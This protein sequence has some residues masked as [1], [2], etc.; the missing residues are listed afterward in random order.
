MARRYNYLL[1]NG[2]KLTGPAERRRGGGDKTP[3]YEFSHAQQ[4]IS[5]RIGKAA[6]RIKQLPAEACPGGEAILTLTM[7]PR[8]ISKTDFPESL[9]N[10]LGLRSVGSRERTV[11][12][13]KW[14]ID[15]HPQEAYTEEL[16]VAG[17][18]SRILQLKKYVDEFTPTSTGHEDLLHIEDIS[19][20]EPT[21]KLKL[22]N[23]KDSPEG[24]LEVVLHN[25]SHVDVLSAFNEYASPLGARVDFARR[26]DVGGLTFVPVA[27]NAKAAARLADFSFLRVARTMP[28]LRPLYPSIVR[29]TAKE[30]ATLP[31][32]TAITDG[33][34]ALIFDGGIPTGER[35]KLQPWVKVI[36]PPS[37]GP[38]VP[39]LEAHGLA[40]TS[41]FLFG[42]ISD[43]NGLR[44]PI[45][46]V[47]HVRVLDSDVIGSSDPYYYDVLDRI[48]AFFDAE[49]HR[50]VFIN[51]SVGPNLPI[52]DDEITLW[53]ARLDSRLAS[54]EW[55]TTVAAGNDGDKAALFGLNRIQPPADGVNLIGVGACNRTSS[56][57]T[58]ADYSC[59]G[60]GRRPGFVKPDGLAFG[61][62]EDEP[63]PVLSSGSVVQGVQGTSVAAPWA[64]RSG[65]TIKA[66]LGQSLGPLAI[67]ALMVHRA[68]P[69]EGLPL[70]EIGWGRFESD[71]EKLITCEDNEALVIYQGDLPE[72]QYLHAPIPLP[73][74]HLK[75][76]VELEATLVI[77]TD[78]DPSHASA[79]TRS[80]LET[81]FRP[82]ADRFTKYKD[83]KVS[84]YPTT[85]AFFSER[86]LYGGSE[87]K[88][89]EG[90]KWEPCV[91]G[92]VRMRATSLKSPA[93]DIYNH[94]R[95]NGTASQSTDKT[96]Y[97]LVVT[98]RAVRVRDL[99]SQVVRAYANILIPLRPQIRIEVSH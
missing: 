88:Q 71:P 66:Q 97:A 35:T 53:T 14:G 36:E 5:E 81:A 94:R 24:W 56:A 4:R 78:V 89:R 51:I 12:P 83:G 74:I 22:V 54:G 38:S 49:G 76:Y 59:P 20:P 42:P 45:C 57:W 62:S 68:L 98:V 95:A 69:A 63:F 67:R 16:F 30:F 7:H 96:K 90:G 19:Y 79:Y 31:E 17:P 61:G 46:P 43:V 80:G 26:R 1:G 77:A 99:Y 52:Y 41:A 3:P 11:I 64:L 18:I 39:D 70:S 47:D 10:S 91:R 6:E 33:W 93:F 25:Q 27:A 58:R 84:Y 15:N 75:G 13:E 28:T 2:E 55:V 23:D 50:Y 73:S 72:G 86:N 9:L 8:Y 29:A 40:V 21:S 48:M 60:P 87:L 32:D 92:K 34:R 65:A 37:V 44:R 85:A 82:H